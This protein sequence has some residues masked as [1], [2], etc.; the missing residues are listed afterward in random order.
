MP[1]PR[2]SR[3]EARVVVEGHLVVHVFLAIIHVVVVLVGSANESALKQLRV[4]P[5]PAEG[6]PAARSWPRRA[7]AATGHHHVTL[8]RKLWDQDSVTII[9]NLS[10]K[11]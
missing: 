11:K 3:L 7:R 8:R 6:I 5:R 9:Q 10:A 2:D 1:Q 4:I